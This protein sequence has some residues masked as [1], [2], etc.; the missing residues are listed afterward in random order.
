MLTFFLIESVS[1]WQKVNYLGEVLGNYYGLCLFCHDLST[2]ME[3]AKI[4]G[5]N[6]I[7]FV[8]LPLHW[9][10]H[11]RNV[12]DRGIHVYTEKSKVRISVIQIKLLDELEKENLPRCE[13]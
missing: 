9:H 8:I 6:T 13:K 4:T 10:M 2:E 5:Y 12:S 3:V 1:F 11:G 7:R